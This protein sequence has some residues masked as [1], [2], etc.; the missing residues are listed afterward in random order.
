MELVKLKYN[1][2]N[3]NETMLEYAFSEKL[4][5]ILKNEIGSARFNPT[6]T[7][8]VINSDRTLKAINIFKTKKIAIK[9]SE[10]IQEEF[11][12]NSQ[13]KTKEEADKLVQMKANH[14]SYAIDDPKFDQTPLNLKL[15]LYNYQK[16]GVSYGISKNGRFLLGDDMGLGKT[17]QGIALAAYYKKD[18]PVLVIAPSS[19]LFNWK[20]EFMTWLDLDEKDINVIKKGKQLPKGKITIASYDYALKRCDRIKEYLGVRGVLIVDEAHNMKNNKSKR[21]EAIITIA[22]AAKR[23]IIITG[24][25][26]LNKPIEIWPLLYAINP[27]NPEWND[28]NKFAIKYCEGKIIKINKKR[29]FS[30]TGASQIEEFHDLIRNEVMVRRLKT[31]DGVLDQLP[32]KVRVTQYFETDEHYT[33]N[34]NALVNKLREN[35][36]TYHKLTNGNLKDVKKHLFAD[37]SESVEED[38]FE[39][40]RLAGMAK[41][42]MINDWIT[43]KIE[44]D[45]GKLIIFGHHKDFLSK[46]EEHLVKSSI[47]YIKIDGSVSK[48]NRFKYTEQ[49]QKDPEIQIA[50]LSINA[51]SVGLTLTSASHVLIGEIPWTPA[52]AQQAECRAHRNGQEREVTCYYAIANGTFDGALWNMISK[53]S[54]VLSSMLDGGFGDEMD[55]ALNAGDII[56]AVI[57]EVDEEI[58]NERLVSN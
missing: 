5:A 19:L 18:W 30:A 58:K 49:F 21:T 4:N 38:V 16:A 42:D 2:E 10:E 33:E 36:R 39:A 8:W 17:P 57:N 52:L 28:Y 12:L 55:V 51:A 26:F 41:V 14:P 11:Q 56:D 29:I 46:I 40:Y 54:S 37:L 31:D 50:L 22:H 24:T 32:D 27:L 43:D 9:I 35:I 53:K 20:K 15:S 44:G 34:I 3:Y 45:I 13:G 6:H 47:K 25:P 1:P 7:C 23:A 48:E